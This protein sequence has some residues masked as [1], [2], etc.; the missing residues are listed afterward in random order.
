[1]SEKFQNKY[2]IPSARA[3]WHD[4]DGGMYFITI[5]TANQESFF[6]NIHD[7]K[8][9]FSDIGLYAEEQIKNVRSHYPYAEIPLWVVMPNHIHLIVVIDN[10]RDGARS[11]S[12]AGGRASVP[13]ITKCNKFPCVRNHCQLLLVELNQP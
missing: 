1:M 3:T 13:L 2:R 11:V 8:M 4:Y 5:C 9:F 12:T 7:G 10:G 6:G